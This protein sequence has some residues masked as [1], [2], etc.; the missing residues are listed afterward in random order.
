MKEGTGKRAASTSVQDYLASIPADAQEAL[1]NL[2]E[3]IRKVVPEAVEVISYQIP[4]F[5]YNE[6]ML[7]AYSAH[8]NHCSLHLMSKSLMSAYKEELKP[9]E[10]TTASIHFTLNH[11]LPTALV[12]KLIKARIDENEAKRKN[13]AS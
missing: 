2:R 8:K 6:R 13:K 3:I 4:T 9:Y 5:R 12:N 10:T 7:V 11:P 1:E